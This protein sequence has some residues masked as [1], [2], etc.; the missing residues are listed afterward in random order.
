MLLVDGDVAAVEELVDVGAEQQPIRH[1]V[2]AAECVWL[3]VRRLEHRQRVL[4]RHRARALIRVR[5]LD[6]EA[7][8][9]EARANEPRYIKLIRALCERA[10]HTL[11]RVTAGDPA[12]EH[13]GTRTLAWHFIT[14]HGHH[15]MVETGGRAIMFRG[16]SK[17]DRVCEVDVPGSEAPGSAAVLNCSLRASS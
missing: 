1:R 7:T 5:H 2:L 17:T 11:E 3:Y 15:Y 12:H 8:L 10:G 9:P 16:F 4:R 14:D 6:S 13:D